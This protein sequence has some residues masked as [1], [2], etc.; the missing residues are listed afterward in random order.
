MD[1]VTG[2]SSPWA[3]LKDLDLSLG[4][5]IMSQLF[6]FLIFF[7]FWACHR[8]GSLVFTTVLKAYGKKTIRKKTANP[9]PQTL[10][11]STNG[12]RVTR[13]KTKQLWP[14]GVRVLL[15]LSPSNTKRTCL[16]PPGPRTPSPPSLLLRGYW[17][18]RVLNAA[19]YTMPPSRGIGC[20][21]KNVLGFTWLGM[22]YSPSTTSFGGRQS[23]VSYLPLKIRLC[24]DRGTIV[25]S[26]RSP[27][28]GGFVNGGTSLRL[29][30]DSVRNLRYMSRSSRISSQSS[31][32]SS[33]STSVRTPF[34]RY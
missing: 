22:V 24:T 6:L 7:F 17:G 10:V 3:K 13:S 20:R 27:G 14:D 23:P 32:V 19:A 33:L 5:T 28:G 18:F 12:Y 26:G 15:H 9:C 25:L 21:P 30:N 8:S 31:M 16:S 1:S 4:T 34:T 11:F 2:F 29:L